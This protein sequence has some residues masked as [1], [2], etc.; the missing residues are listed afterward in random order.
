MD[1]C[2]QSTTT[3]GE[4]RRR[5]EMEKWGRIFGTPSF[6]PLSSTVHALLSHKRTT[7]TVQPSPLNHLFVSPPLRPLSTAAASGRIPRGRSRVHRLFCIQPRRRPNCRSAQ[8]DRLRLRGR[9]PA[10]GVPAGGRRH[11]RGQGKLRPLLHRHLQRGSLHQSFR[12]LPYPFGRGSRQSE[13]RERQ[14]LL[15]ES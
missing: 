10:L 7:R 3:S 14:P 4:G 6:A 11:R 8:Q 1:D 2:S 9:S 13:V 5:E 15:P 12:Q